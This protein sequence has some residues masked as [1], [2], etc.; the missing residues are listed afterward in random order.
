MAVN[1]RNLNYKAIFK[2]NGIILLIIGLSMVPALL[3]SL[4]YDEPGNTQ[5]I[6]KSMAVIVPLGLVL[7]FTMR[8]S[9]T[10]FRAREGYIAVASC[11][12]TASLFGML[13]YFFTGAATSFSTA[14]FESAAGFTTTGSTVMDAALLG[15]GILMWKATSSWIGGMGILIF[16]ISVFPALG[17]NGQVIARLETPAPVLE[18][19]TIRMTDSAK[20]LYITY[21]SFT[22]L[23][24]LLLELGSSM[25]TFDA[26]ANS[27]STIST[28]GLFLHPGGLEYYGSAYVS[29]IICIF[30][31][32]GSIN[33]I[34]Y[35]YLFR[36]N[37]EALK[38]DA[39]VRVFAYMLI[40]AA[41]IGFLSLFISGGLSAGDSIKTSAVEAISNMTTT[42]FAYSDMIWPAS[43]QMLF[44]M[45]MFSGGC[46]ASTSGSLK[47]IRVMFLFKYVRRGMFRRLHP[48][49]VTSIKL[50]GRNVPPAVV[51]GI[52]VF[53]LAFF[54][55]FLLSCVIL[56]LQ[57]YSLTTTMST[58]IA[59]IST[60]GQ[61]LTDSG[62]LTD[63]FSSFAAPLKVYMGILM[64]VGRLELFTIIIMFTRAFW[65]R[66]K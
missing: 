17:I 46:S 40:G 58:A 50:N 59:M 21:I 22:I 53:I 38:N 24:F 51:S 12:L 2:L 15:K 66:K 43:C 14:F 4:Y 8:F 48:H 41:V 42:G 11:W 20:I 16:I 23:E 60:T 56:S 31:L 7:F 37:A 13:P 1:N 62:V 65:N 52:S 49:A 3:C 61:A 10:I 64:L 35:F 36:R 29:I 6:L 34:T 18:K 57:G 54:G 55:V 33:F 25:P 5:G 9:K 27:M 28:G 45:L 47:F 30:S 19:A 26:L 63:N 39:E 44:L 32:V